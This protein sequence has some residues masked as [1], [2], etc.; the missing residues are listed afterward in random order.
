MAEQ[1]AEQFS[2]STHRVGLLIAVSSYVW[3]DL[4]CFFVDRYPAV[5]RNHKGRPLGPRWKHPTIVPSWCNLHQHLKLLSSTCSSMSQFTSELTNQVILWWEGS[6]WVKCLLIWIA[7][8]T[9]YSE[10]PSSP[11]LTWL[12][13]HSP[14]SLASS[15]FS[16]RQR[17]MSS[18][19]ASKRC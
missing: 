17:W 11:W 6:I 13:N 5:N 14:T 18:C 2:C 1:R 16:M 12:P 9:T 19:T 10:P 15:L 4:L 8:T 3:M 7:A